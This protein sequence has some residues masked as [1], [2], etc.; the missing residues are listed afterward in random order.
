L[1]SSFSGA[2]HPRGGSAGVSPVTAHLDILGGDAAIEV[3]VRNVRVGEG[4]PANAPDLFATGTEDAAVA[5][6]IAYPPD[7]AIVPLNL[8]DLE[9]HWRDG[10][11]HDLFEMSMVNDHVDLKVY[12][13]ATGGTG[14]APFSTAEW[15][16]G[17][18]GGR[19]LTVNIRGLTIATPQ[20]SA[21]PPH[22]LLL[23]NN[24]LEGGLYYWAA[25][26]GSALRHLPPRLA[27]GQPAGRSTPP[28]R[29]AVASPA[30]L[31]RDGGT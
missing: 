15:Y 23:T 14:W 25:A 26:A 1:I 19:Q 24:D 11:G 13:A 31:S 9:M 5:P 10:F 16:A 18:M 7:Q 21:W 27:T 28:P 12:V 20:Q 22:T 30:A 4:A 3:F 2:T 17:A 8:G 6:T 29:P